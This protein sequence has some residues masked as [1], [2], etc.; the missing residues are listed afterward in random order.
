MAQI[1]IE[2]FLNQLASGKNQKLVSLP[3][4][5]LS[6]L[7]SL[8][9]KKLNKRVLLIAPS[10]ERSR[11]LSSEIELFNGAKPL[12]FS[13]LEYCQ[14]GGDETSRERAGALARI[15]T[16]DAQLLIAEA[17]SIFQPTIPKP[18]LQEY[19]F[20]LKP[21]K[22][23]DREN[24]ISS[25]ISA[26]YQMADMVAEPGEISVRGGIMDL[27][28]PS[29]H[30]PI[31]IEWFGEEI[32]TLRLFEP[33]TQRSKDKVEQYLVAPGCELV[34]TKDRAEKLKQKI[35]RLAEELKREKGEGG[36]ISYV[37]ALQEI[38]A[39][40]E[41]EGRFYAEE[42]FLFL[43]DDK[44]SV[45]EYLEKDWLIVVCEEMMVNQSLAES[46]KKA[47]QDWARLIAGGSLLPSPQ[48]IFL[49]SEMVNKALSNF[50][51]LSIGAFLRGKEERE[52]G[53]ELELK[54]ELSE[55]LERELLIEPN[56]DLRF[57]PRLSEPISKLVE[58]IKKLNQEGFKIILASSSLSQAERLSMLFREQGIYPAELSQAEEFFAPE[59]QVAIGVGELREGFRVIE[60]G[61][62]IISEREVFGEKISRRISKERMEWR[63]DDLS[64]LEPG[65]YVVHIKHG[66]GIYRGMKELRVYSFEKWDYLAQ[67]ER[68]T[69]SQPC[70]ELEYA[71]SARLYLPVDQVNQ[72]QKYRSPK[73]QPV[74]L[75][76][77]G[78]K[79]FE[80]AKRKA[81]Q[82]IAELA[83]ELIELYASR[84]VLS[85]YS[86]PEPD[87]TYREFE[88]SFEYEETQDQ[89]K[90]IEEVIE[91][92]VQP[93]VMDRLVLGDVGY[94]KTEVA[95]R[96]SFI[97]AMASR[98]VAF[99]CPTTILAQQH[100]DTFCKRLNGWPLEIRLLSRFQT[101]S[102]QKKIIEELKTGVCDIVIGTHRLLSD[103]VGFRDLGLLVIDEEQSFGVAQKE[104][105]KKL[106]KNVDCLSL[107]ATPIPRTL[108]FSLLGLRPL[109]TIQTPPLDRQ[110]IHT[111]LIHFSPQIIREAILRELKRAGQVF[112]VHNRVQGIEQIARWLSGLVPE[113]K[114]ALAHGQMPERRLEQVMRDFYQGKCDV[115]V[116]TAIIESGLDL[117]RANT[118]IINRA[119]QFG[120]AQLYQLR[121]RIGRSR[122]KGYAYLVAP[123]RSEL[124]GDGLKRLK[125]LK[126][127][128]ELGSGFRLAAYDLKLRGAGNLL[129]KEQTGHISRVGYE[130]YLKLLER[131]IRE[132]KGEELPEEFEPE[133]KLAIPAYLPSGYIP[134]ETERLS[135]YKR[136]AVARTEEDLDRLWE[137]LID[138]YGRGPEEVENLVR[139]VKIKIWMRRLRIPRLEADEGSGLISFDEASKV[140]FDYL[141]EQAKTQ[142]DRFRLTQAQGMIYW[143]KEKER[144]FEEL[145]E[146][147]KKIQL[148]G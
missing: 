26:G 134:G 39:N 30:L 68:P 10:A 95:L 121:G 17:K 3:G 92:L 22:K 128:S 27:F 31:R 44:H 111:E 100:Y 19:L 53:R 145:E 104:R 142:P 32:E 61:L 103:D 78:G 85:G 77:I 14:L 67:R 28:S 81:E 117:P 42:R 87:P 60:S 20:E 8:I 24:F 99:L 130:L 46:A 97:V 101:R 35:F 4:S 9:Q 123:S 88:I 141:I 131:K 63:E 73:E 83:E 96:A 34:I 59:W 118:I 138:R 66:I 79:S 58:E 23:I 64:D 6:W 115:L 127:F 113:A 1:T 105:L 65:D 139:A 13:A 91:D 135:W 102:E 129:G 94:G 72:L 147:F 16:G 15:F 49:E 106:K 56:P 33:S 122:A 57:N 144:R 114:I 108:E 98:Q 119:E 143:F 47:E 54:I 132:L 86:Y 71:D 69:I 146:L 62:V 7:V 137:E 140:N 148:N 5:S 2:D 110:A 109:S 90:V 55:A 41:R 136:L 120:L 70:L 36:K 11:E 37:P 112:F 29:A 82:A 93:K 89:A 43:I 12:L 51:T 40:L 25:L 38:V 84:E 107:S 50:Q 48:Q 133:I 74:K 116:S 126:E 52:L 125:A 21:G 76:Q 45:L 124:K 18:L 80:L 75:D